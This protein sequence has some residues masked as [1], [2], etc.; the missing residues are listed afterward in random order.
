MKR[1]L[2]KNTLCKVSVVGLSNLKSILF[3][4]ILFQIQSNVFCSAVSISGEITG[5]INSIRGQIELSGEISKY[6]RSI[7]TKYGGIKIE[8]TWQDAIV[9]QSNV[10]ESIFWMEDYET[11]TGEQY[12]NET[13][14]K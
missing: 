12:Y 11:K 3:L 1:E 2:T 9:Y 13:Y 7:T 6:T 10:C 5:I 4:T 14:E 8:Q